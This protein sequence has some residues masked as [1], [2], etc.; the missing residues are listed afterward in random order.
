VEIRVISG[1]VTEVKAS[2]VM[3]GLFEKV[4]NPDDYTATLDNVL[5]GTISQLMS[6]GEIKGKFGELTIIH[7]LGKLFAERVVILGLGKKQEF[8]LDKIRGV[9]AEACRFLQKKGIDDAAT[10]ALGVGV[11][12]ITP[13]SASQAITEGA[14]LGLYSF[15]RHITKEPEYGEIKQLSIVANSEAD[16]S[17]LEHG[18]DKGKILAEAAKL[19][20]DMVNEPANYMTPGHMV[21]MA[22][23]LAKDY[24][25]ELV[26][27]EREKMLELGMGALL[28]VAQGSAQSPKFII[29]NYKENDSNEIDLALI[30]KG[31]TFDSGGIS[32]KPGRKMEEMKGDMAGGAAVIAAIAA[33]SQLKPAI[34]V[35]A[36]VPAV[37]NLPGGR[38]FKPGDILT[39]MT[40]KTVEII[41]T[42]A[43][44]RLV[45]A[46]AL[47]FVNKLKPKQIIDVATL[48]GACVV[49]LGDVCTGAFSNNQE[50]ANK[51]VIAGAKA[52]ELIWQMPMYTEYKELN[53]S[54]VADIKNVGDN[55]A[56]AITAA[57]FLAEFVGST[58]WVHLDIAG[59]S[60]SNKERNYLVKGATGVPVRT[61]INLALAIAK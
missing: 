24:D 18:R 41:S 48:T 4:K 5:G 59:T 38:A 2:A 42:D 9:V 50:L 1:D 30:G 15:R 52:G 26:V 47:C 49:A 23:Q 11:G 12:G 57:Q 27:L 10:I 37:E 31:I 55:N 3:V 20:R 44:G 16:I 7:S 60:M 58:P 43:E 51:V 17:L 33:I 21:K 53:K 32:L 56:G 14:L 13:K 28:G 29:L 46:D 36:I 22:K 61:L 40:G 25:L 19:A 8:T 45:M 35:T 39:T 54:D 6:Q 34:N